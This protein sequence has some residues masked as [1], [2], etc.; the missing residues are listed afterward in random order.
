MFITLSGV[1]ITIVALCCSGAGSG[2]GASSCQLID[3]SR[4]R[5]REIKLDESVRADD[6]TK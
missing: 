6:L 5:F 4:G 2:S 1:K 3:N